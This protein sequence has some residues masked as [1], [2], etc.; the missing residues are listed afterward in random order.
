MEKVNEIIKVIEK[1]TRFEDL[2]FIEFDGDS[3][4]FIGFNQGD[5][6]VKIK[7]TVFNDVFVIYKEHY[8]KK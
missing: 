6:E 5:E 7:V 3:Y 1:I 8:M 4:Q 2:E